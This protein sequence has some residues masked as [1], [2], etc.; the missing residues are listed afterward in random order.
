MTTLMPE[1]IVTAVE[2]EAPDYELM[3]ID[4]Q[5][6]LLDC[7]ECL[8]DLT[9]SVEIAVSTGQIYFVESFLAAAQTYL[10]ERS[11]PIDDSDAPASELNITIV[12]DVSEQ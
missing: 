1:A 12:T 10:A 5:N 3:V 11:V 7:E 4:L 9:R 8:H 2:D 6:R